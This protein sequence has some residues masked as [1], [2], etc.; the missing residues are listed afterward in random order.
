MN[1]PQTQKEVAKLAQ[2]LKE[3][4]QGFGGLFQKNHGK[5]VAKL[6]P[7][8]MD[9]MH[10]KVMDLSKKQAERAEEYSKKGD[11]EKAAY[12][13]TRSE[14]MKAIGEELGPEKLA[15]RAENPLNVSP[16]EFQQRF[17]EKLN[18]VI[19]DYQK[20]PD[21][22]RASASIAFH[23]MDINEMQKLDQDLVEE[24]F[25]IGNR[26]ERP[27]FAGLAAGETALRERARLE[28]E[29]PIS[30]A[31]KNGKEPEPMNPDGSKYEKD[32]KPEH[33]FPDRSR[34]QEP[35]ISYHN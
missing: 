26:T 10:K 23:K 24:K 20:S 16:E 6:N 9:N 7:Q 19:E 15:E 31:Y 29:T 12:L 28:Q 5:G 1:S 2:L 35:D 8:E 32:D 18:T 25:N 13:T 21:F 11:H 27:I 33:K 30:A 4:L 34:R 14:V 17:E 3:L 22:D